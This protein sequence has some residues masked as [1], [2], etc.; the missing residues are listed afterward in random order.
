[1]T[2]NLYLSEIIVERTDVRIEKDAKR[3]YIN[4]CNDKYDRRENILR[5]TL[6]RIRQ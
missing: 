1:M 3:K 4:F 2:F 5:W 6:I